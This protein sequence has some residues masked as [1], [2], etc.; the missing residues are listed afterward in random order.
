[1]PLRDKL[2]L[3][4]GK[5]RPPAFLRKVCVHNGG[6]EL[7]LRFRG[8]A[9]FDLEFVLGRQLEVYSCVQCGHTTLAEVV[10]KLYQEYMATGQPVVVGR[11]IKTE[12]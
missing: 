9:G 7:A 1:M 5:A 10:W 6:P 11:N 2:V 8:D 12:A 3:K 4:D